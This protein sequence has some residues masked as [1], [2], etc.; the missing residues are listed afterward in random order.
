MLTWTKQNSQNRNDSSK[1][2]RNSTRRY[3][4][5]S[6]IKSKIESEQRSSLIQS[7]SSNLNLNTNQDLILENIENNYENINNLKKYSR[8][9]V[10]WN[11]LQEEQHVQSNQQQ[12]TNS[13]FT[14]TLSFEEIEI[15]LTIF[16]DQFGNF[17]IPRNEEEYREKKYNFLLDNKQ[18]SKE[19]QQRIYLATKNA[20]KLFKSEEVI[21]EENSKLEESS[22]I[23]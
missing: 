5:N 14:D 13:Y 18:I 4:K 7:K 12:N 10:T 23:F 6:T 19:E 17:I 2:L 11:S 16:T 8:S 20:E 15:P 3:T 21:Q 9:T 1:N 22:I